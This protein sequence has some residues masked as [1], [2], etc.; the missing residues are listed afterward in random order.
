MVM[1]AGWAGARAMTSTSGPGISLMGEF[2]GLAYYAEVPGVVFDIQRVGPSTGLADAHRAGRH[3]ARPRCC[4]TATRKQILLIPG[5]PEECYTFA[6]EA[7]DLAERFQTLVF[8]MSDLDLGHEHLDVGAVPVSGQA[9]RSRQ[10]ARRRR[11][12]SGSA[13]SG[14]ATRTST[15]TASRTARCPATACPRI[16][17]AARATTSAASTASGPTTTRTTSIGS[18]ASSRR[19]SSFVPPP[20]VDDADADIGIIGYGS[21]H[22]AIDECRDQL[23]G[24]SGIRTGYLRHPRVSVHERRSRVRRAPPARLRGRAEP[25]RADAARC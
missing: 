24:E 4:R 15:A 23:L 2:A 1:G 16:S 11:R 3:P 22:S 17:R 10:A 14:D 8:V 20:I 25:R 7:F 6:M 5:S 21:S 12:W 9:A 13:A 19:P 18:R